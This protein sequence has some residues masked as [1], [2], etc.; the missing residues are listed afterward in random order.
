MPKKEDKIQKLLEENL[1][2]TKEV[3]QLTKRV[4]KYMVGAQIIGIIK[5][6]IILAPII[7]AIV[8]LPAFIKNALGNYQHLLNLDTSQLKNFLPK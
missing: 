1:A 3:H 2:L 6:I 4:N 5:L 8:Y 7:W